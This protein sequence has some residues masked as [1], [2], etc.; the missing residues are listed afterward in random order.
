ML[1]VNVNIYKLAGMMFMSSLNHWTT[2]IC[3]KDYMK[4]LTQPNLAKILLSV[5][6]L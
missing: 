3:W 2:L 5:L 6:Q 4:N 1:P